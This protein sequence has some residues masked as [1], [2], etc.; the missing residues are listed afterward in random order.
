LDYKLEE[1]EQIYHQLAASEPAEVP[2]KFPHIVITE[3]AFPSKTENDLMF[4]TQLNP[5]KTLDIP[6]I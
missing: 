2:D 5:Q 6:L 4:Y 1:L 3:S